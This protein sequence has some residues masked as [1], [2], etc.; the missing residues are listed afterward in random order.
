MSTTLTLHLILLTLPTVRLC[1]ISKE[2]YFLHRLSPKKE[3]TSP[4]IFHNN[5]KPFN[6]NIRSNL[7][8]PQLKFKARLNL[9]LNLKLKLKLNHN[10]ITAFNKC[11]KQNRQKVL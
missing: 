3:L 1:L 10:K 11:K 2:L 4:K 7:N 6:K 8:N 5:R 9:N